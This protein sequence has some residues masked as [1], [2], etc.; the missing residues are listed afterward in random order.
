MVER[1]QERSRGYFVGV[2]NEV[3]G[4]FRVIIG[5]FSIFWCFFMKQADDG[6]VSKAVT[7]VV[8]S[9]DDST[10]SAQLKCVETSGSG[11]FWLKIGDFSTFWC[12][13]M[14]PSDAERVLMAPMMMVGSRDSLGACDSKTAR[15]SALFLCPVLDGSCGFCSELAVVLGDGGCET[16]LLRVP[17]LVWTRA[18]SSRCSTVLG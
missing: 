2:L 12:L 3:F 6:R 1:R 10:S 17:G 8:G 14:K 9:G 11:E 15:K 5:R 7:M 16:T 18:T 4:E 13:F